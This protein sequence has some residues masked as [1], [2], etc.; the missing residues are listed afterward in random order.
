MKQIIEAEGTK[1]PHCGEPAKWRVC[2]ECGKGAWIID[3]GHMDQPRPIAAGR[4]DGS[5][6]YKDFCED[7]A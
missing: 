2:S 6:L 4:E 5:E 7:C 1:C 3:C